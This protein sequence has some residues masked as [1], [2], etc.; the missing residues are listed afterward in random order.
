[1][2]KYWL[3]YIGYVV[4]L[5]L[6]PAGSWAT[7]DAG[8][9][10]KS[11]I[12]LR[13][14][15]QLG[16]DEK[17]PRMLVVIDESKGTGTGYDQ[18][19]A[20][21]NL[22]GVLSD[23]APALPQGGA[24]RHVNFMTKTVAPFRDVDTQ[25]RYN[26]SFDAYRIGSVTTST[27][28]SVSAML[29]VKQNGEDW[30]YMFIGGKAT[31]D[32]QAPALQMMNLGTSVTLTVDAHQE[33]LVPTQ[34]AAVALLLGKEENAQQQPVPGIAIQSVLK[35]TDGQVLRLVE[36]GFTPPVV[37]VPHLKVQ[38]PGGFL[39]DKDMEYSREGM[40]NYLMRVTEKGEYTVEVSI[41]LGPYQPGGPLK[42][43]QKVVY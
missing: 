10:A 18:V 42:V 38:G 30:S 22:N 32:A 23:D 16:P 4:L 40:C 2:Q 33:M 28:V 15:I 25:A 13:Y 36:K 11:N 17:C 26:V 9:T 14:S 35:D 21:Q 34:P 27:Q 1:M 31:I 39:L 7:D 37:A 29:S 8:Y 20:D 5:A 19:I 12:P 43:S 6:F 3:R 41:D 24:Q